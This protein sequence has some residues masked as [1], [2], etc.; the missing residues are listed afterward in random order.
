MNSTSSHSTVVVAR[1]ER[2][3]CRIG[4][5]I[6][7]LALAAF[8]ARPSRADMERPDAWITTK[9]KMSLLTTENVPSTA[10]N[11]D[12]VDGK[13]TLHGIVSTDSEKTRAEQVARQIEGVRTVNNLL[14]VVPSSR[15]E[16]V[17]IADAQLQKNVE[18]VLSRDAALSDSSIKIAS[19]HD[20]V[21]LLSG[22]AKTLSA[23]R[24]AL[25]DARAVPGVKKVS[26]E[27]QS[28][29]K[30]GDDE[31]STSSATMKD[32]G[33]SMKS[34]AYDAWITTAAKSRLLATADVP[35]LD[36]NVDTDHEVVT[37]FGSVPSE[38]SKKL[39]ETEVKKVDGVKAVKNEL[40]VVPQ[41]MAKATEHSDD[42]IQKAIDDKLQSRSELKD[43]SISVQ[44]AKGVARLTGTVASQSDRLLALSTTRSVS[45]VRSVIDELQVNTP[46]SSR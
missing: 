31:I 40:Q 23:H 4:I 25:A 16:D 29:D 10:I 3:R 17:K 46:V 11:V 39:A 19:V 18:A 12:T 7:V 43:S 24:R 38:A 34:A 35:A 28:P 9:V 15:K 5:G 45:G 14:Q 33:S 36:I 20:G 1:R 42:S 8:A 44:V 2:A 37:L 26:S 13:V 41:S 6:L 32:K 22:N 30:L 27:I 21:V